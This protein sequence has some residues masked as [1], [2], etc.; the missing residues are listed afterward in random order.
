VVEHDIAGLI[1]VSAQLDACRSLLEQ[2]AELVLPLFDWSAHEIAAVQLQKIEGIEVRLIL[3]SAAPPQQ[4]KDGKALLIANDNLAIDQ[5]RPDIKRLDRRHDS[6]EQFAPIV[7]I[8][9]KEVETPVGAP[10]HHPISIVLDLMNPAGAGGR[11]VGRR[12]LAWFDEA[13]WAT[14]HQRSWECS[15]KA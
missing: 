4:I 15:E 6:R 10:S 2:P 9:G 8:A 7:A 11:L 5:A 14:H 3:Y 1:E 13:E 12:W